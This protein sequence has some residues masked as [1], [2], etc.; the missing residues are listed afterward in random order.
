MTKVWAHLH[1]PKWNAYLNGSGDF[2]V[3]SLKSPGQKVRYVSEISMKNCT[4]FVSAAG[5]ER[6]LRT[7]QGNVHAWVIGEETNREWD[8]RG[9][10]KAVYDPWRGGTFV[11]S[12][13]LQPVEF[14]IAVHMIGKDVYYAE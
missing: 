5:R 2:D 7:G 13:T 4:F 12:N 8:Y 11:D 3:I 6:T 1:L 9:W 14:M 10:R